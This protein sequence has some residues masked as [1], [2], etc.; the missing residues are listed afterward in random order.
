MKKTS[1]LLFAVIALFVLCYGAVFAGDCNC[2]KGEKCV[3]K[4]CNCAK[5]GKCACKKNCKDCRDCKK[6]CKDGK[7]TGCNDSDCKDGKCS[8]KH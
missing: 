3:C 5:D 7:C 6:N 8:L 2:A 1:L 4:D